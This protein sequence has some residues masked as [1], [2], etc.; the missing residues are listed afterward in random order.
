MLRLLCRGSQRDSR[1]QLFLLDW[2]FETEERR[3]R[4]PRNLKQLLIL[5]G[6]PDGRGHRFRDTSPVEL[7]LVGVPIE[8]TS[9]FLGH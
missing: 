6:V 9:I 4:Q 5:A 7:L 1:K 3:G 2:T 8:R